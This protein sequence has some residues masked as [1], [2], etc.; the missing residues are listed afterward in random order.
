MKAQIDQAFKNIDFVLK[1]A[2]GKGISQVFRMTSYHPAL[3]REALRCMRENLERYFPLERRPIWTAV[4]VEK[5]AFPE[6][7]IEIEAVAF[8]P[9]I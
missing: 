8:D 9:Q 7:L 4:G 5:L 6:M 3:E 2:G 1:E